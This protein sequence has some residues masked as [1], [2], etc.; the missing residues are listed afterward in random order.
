MFEP[1]YLLHS[2]IAWLTQTDVVSLTLDDGFA[3]SEAVCRAAVDAAPDVVFVCSPNNPTG[4][5]Q[6]VEAVASLAGRADALVIVD[7]AYI[8]FGGSHVPATHR[9][10]PERR[11]H[12][13][14]VEGVRTR[15]RADRLRARVAGRGRRICNASACRTTCPR[16]RRP[17]A[18][19]RSVTRR[20]RWRS[21]TRSATSA[22]GSGSRWRDVRRHGLPSDANFVLFVP[23]KP[24]AEVWQGLVDRGVLI[25]DLSSVV[26]NALRVTA[27]T[28]AEVDLFLSALEEVL[29]A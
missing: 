25:R 12:A 10:A 17:P 16:S 14:D 2:R 21:W 8:E 1:T 20:R 26:P 22:T 9:Q 4:N 7:E 11:R 23:P 13:H 3:L 5:A 6:P 27:G 24:A 28:G 29:A 15:R 19:P 18:S